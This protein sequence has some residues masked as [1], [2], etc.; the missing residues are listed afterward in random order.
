MMKINALT[1]DLSQNWWKFFPN[2]SK[3]GRII[4]AIYPLIFQLLAGSP[5]YYFQKV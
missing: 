5:T 4:A 2:G 3:G 1:S